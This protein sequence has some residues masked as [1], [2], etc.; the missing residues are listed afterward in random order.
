MR[1][2]SAETDVAP[3]TSIRFP[4]SALEV[5]CAYLQ[6]DE[7]V[8]KL[9]DQDT[10]APR[11]L[12]PA[13]RLYYFQQD[14]VPVSRGVLVADAIGD[15]KSGARMLFRSTTM[16]VYLLWAM[17]SLSWAQSGTQPPSTVHIELNT[18][19]DTDT[20][21]RLTF[22]ASNTT[23]SDIDK[24]VFETVIFDDTG[25]V[26]TLSLF[27]FRALPTGRPRVRQF[28]VPGVACA[29]VG[30]VLINGANTCETAGTD[31]A[32]C[33]SSLSLSTRIAVELLG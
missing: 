14:K 28:D 30:R 13:T 27:D 33:A 22:V 15:G 12:L 17:P 23:A 11:D 6:T 24:A 26:V 7:K 25:G 3:G 2:N 32:V 10:A 29:S 16:C 8:L 5:A 18:L 19:T 20:A 31:S 21:C 1:S 4:G 9:L